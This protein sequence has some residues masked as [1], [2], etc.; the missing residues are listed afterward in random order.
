MGG[1]FNTKRRPRARAMPHTTRGAATRDWKGTGKPH[2]NRGKRFPAEVLTGDEV[3]GLIKAA[4]GRAPTGIRNRA[5]LGL[6]YRGG[7]RISEALALEVKDLD[8][9][10]GTVRVLHG[11]GDLD[12][13]REY[14]GQATTLFRDMG[15]T[16]WLE[17]AGIF[18]NTF[19]VG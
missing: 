16:W 6:L 3:R 5:L 15:M 10:A 17:Q 1:Q 4:S 19:D 12:Q 8:Q 11:K 14:L 18:G 13:A 9:N 2:P 7:L